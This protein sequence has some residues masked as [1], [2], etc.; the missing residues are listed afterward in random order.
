MEGS[1]NKPNTSE[2][3]ITSFQNKLKLEVKLQDG[4]TPRLDEGHPILIYTF[5][6]SN[7]IVDIATDYS[8]NERMEGFV[9][10]NTLAPPYIAILLGPVYTL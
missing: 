5:P 10:L 4:V 7:F 1:L 2:S 3:E 6:G 8:G 9:N